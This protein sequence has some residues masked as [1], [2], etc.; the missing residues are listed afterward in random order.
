MW[1]LLQQESFLVGAAL[2]VVYQ[3]AKFG[4]LY[5]GDPVTSRYLSLLPGANVR[6]LAGAHAYHLALAA[7]LGTSLLAYFLLCHLS[8]SV[9]TGAARVLGNKEAGNLL[10]D[11]PYPLYIAALFMGLTQPIIPGFSKFEVAQRVFFHGRIEVPRRII[12]F[13]ESVISAI[14]RRSGAD[15]QRLVAEVHRLTNGEFLANLRDYGDLAYYRLQLEKLELGNG[16]AE[17]AIEDSSTKEL[18][19]LIERLVLCALVAVMRQS[20]PKSLSK[21]GEWLEIPAS[22]GRR[23]RVGTL[24]ASVIA[25]AALFC[26]GFLIIAHILH[27]VEGPA[28]S[29]FG[30]TAGASLWPRSFDEVFG[31]LL[32]IATPMIVSLF[33]ATCLLRSGSDQEA[34]LPP[35]RTPSLINDFLDFV[36]SSS[37]ILVICLLVTVG[38]K[39]GQIFFEYG[40]SHEVPD[41]VRTP[42]RLFLPLVQSVIVLAVCL[43][44]TWYLVS[45]DR[46]PS[47]RTLSFTATIFIIIGLTAFI[48]LLYD[49]TFLDQYLNVHPEDRPGGEHYLFS[50]AA[51]ALVSACAFASVAVFFKTRGRLAAADGTRAGGAGV[52]SGGTPAVPA[53]HRT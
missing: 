5:V 23:Q 4:E 44:T 47:R 39:I 52:L 12:D 24:I 7:F 19:G 2:V 51:N 3:A 30:K 31:E 35:A 25:S 46:D 40:S 22:E 50:V 37:S 10:Q 36:R 43:F 41:A 14:E 21:V 38:I 8:P 9:L 28:A 13:S 15:R 1:D 29:L 49:L 45:G 32:T 34:P 17:G 11:V 20:G 53:L 33:L 27:W 26:V 16:G 42:T 18:R 6:D 48:A